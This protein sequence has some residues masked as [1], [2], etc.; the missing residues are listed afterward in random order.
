MEKIKTFLASN[1]KTA[2]LVRTIIQ[3]A[4]GVVIANLDKIVGGFA[5]APDCKAIIV[6][7][8][9]SVLSPIMAYFGEDEQ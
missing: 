3:G 2:R 4:I 9:M 7:L 6:A 1:T 8:T 5:I